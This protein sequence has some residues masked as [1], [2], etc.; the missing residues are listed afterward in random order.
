MIIGKLDSVRIV[1]EI[2][3]HF[4]SPNWH[5]KAVILLAVINRGYR[6]ALISNFKLILSII[7]KGEPSVAKNVLE[8]PEIESITTL[9]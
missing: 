5:G 3:S 2:F 7:V 8:N 4:G 9:C 6:H 1:A